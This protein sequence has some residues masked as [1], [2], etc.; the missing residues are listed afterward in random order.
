M[1][2]LSN[3]SRTYFLSATLNVHLADKSMSEI[4]EPLLQHCQCQPAAAAAAA[5]E[6]PCH[7]AELPSC[8][9]FHAEEESTSEPE[10][11]NDASP[12]VELAQLF[13]SLSGV[14]SLEWQ[15]MPPVTYSRFSYSRVMLSPKSD[16]GFIATRGAWYKTMVYQLLETG[17]F[18]RLYTLRGRIY[19]H[20]QNLNEHQTPDWKLHFSI[21]P[22]DLEPAWNIMSHWFMEAKCEI[23]MKITTAP[24]EEGFSAGKQ[25]GREITVYIYQYDQRFRC[26]PCYDVLPPVEE[27]AA[28]YR[29]PPLAAAEEEADK[30][31]QVRSCDVFIGAVAESLFQHESDYYLG[32]EFESPYPASFWHSFIREAE[33][34][35]H[36]AGIQSNG[37]CASGDLAL[38]G[39]EYASLRN[40]AF[41]VEEKEAGLQYPSNQAGWNAAQHTNPLAA[42]IALLKLDQKP[43]SC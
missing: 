39:C 4:P 41:V 29:R 8:P 17:G 30:Q 11:S 20:A 21:A 22:A 27:Q 5:A 12:S 24:R 25:R 2:A 9:T 16:H 28:A 40:E 36:A 18:L 13:P 6:C 23:G 35:L 14:P 10:E 34:R 15:D 32:H 1:I 42:T 37:G 3:D 43:S 38:P 31:Q 7:S 33:K 19:W 26:G